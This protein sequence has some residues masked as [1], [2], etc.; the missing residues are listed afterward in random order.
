VVVTLVKWE[1]VDA[2]VGEVMKTTIDDTTMVSEAQ[3]SI[4]YLLRRLLTN[5]HHCNL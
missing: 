2:V 5:F 1:E 3:H 4:S